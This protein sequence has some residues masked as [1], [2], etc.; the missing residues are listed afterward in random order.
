MISDLIKTKYL[1]SIAN[2]LEPEDFDK[3]EEFHR[4]ATNNEGEDEE[5]S[6]VY[7]KYREMNDIE[8]SV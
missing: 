8:T 6:K 2:T 7:N 3:L 5:I 4:R 1:I